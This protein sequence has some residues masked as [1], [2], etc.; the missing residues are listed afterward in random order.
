M[1]DFLQLLV[2][3][4]PFLVVVMFAIFTALIL[5]AYSPRRRAHLDECARIPLRDDDPA[6]REL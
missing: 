1:H 4:R 2:A 6:R 3:V 5:W